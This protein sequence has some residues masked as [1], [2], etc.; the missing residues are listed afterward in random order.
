MIK[1]EYS[2]LLPFGL[3]TLSDTLSLPPATAQPQPKPSVHL[4]P[5]NKE[6]GHAIL[7]MSSQK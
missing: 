2:H 6:A 1:K 3:T 4:E 7:Q 5:T